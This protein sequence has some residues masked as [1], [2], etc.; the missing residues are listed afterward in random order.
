LAC[1]GYVYGLAMAKAFIG[2]GMLTNILLITGDTY[3]KY[4]HPGDR[5]TRFLFGDGASASWITVAPGD[6]IGVRD[7]ICATHGADHE[8]FIIRAG[9]HRLPRSPATSEETIDTHGNVRSAEHIYMDGLGVLNFAKMKVAPLVRQLLARNQLSFADIDVVIF[10]QASKMAMDTLA[11]VL[12]V[13]PE[14]AYSNIGNVGNLVSTSI[15]AALKDAMDAGVAG[16]GKRLL[17]VGFGVGLSTAV[18][19]VDI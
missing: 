4:I 9:A 16:P 17:L 19:I 6:N 3:S 18:A 1:S 7:L 13:P 15:P 14:K 8:K 5:A 12:K 11:K 10:H 2:S